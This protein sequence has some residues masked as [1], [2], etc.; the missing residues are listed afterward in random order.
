MA[1]YIKTEYPYKLTSPNP[2]DIRK[3]VQTIADRDALVDNFQAYESLQT[4]VVEEKKWYEYNGTEWVIVGGSGGESTADEVSYVNDTVGSNNVEEALNKLIADYYYVKPSI[5]SFTSNPIGGIFEIGTVI[6]API[7]FVWDYNKDIT[8]QSLTDCILTDNTVRTASYDT[9]ITSNKT[10]TLTASDDKNT[11]SKTI[12]YTFV[13]PYYVGVSD[14]DILDETGIKA[15]TKKVE[16]KGN[17]TIDYTT[18]QS[19]M[20]FA[21]PSSYGNIT[22]IIDK[23]GFD[24]T[25]SFVKSTVSVN[26]V[27]YFVYCSNKVTGTFKMTFSI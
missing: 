27:D 16:V 13:N 6:S 8:T 3:K 17:K 4:Y 12:S 7:T 22:K 1:K 15:L 9:D 19:Y 2:L 11:I 24:V 10:F 26:G 21:Y 25:S 14:T 18:S 23:N 20:I 5:T